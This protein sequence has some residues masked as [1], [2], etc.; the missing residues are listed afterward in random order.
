MGG[1]VADIRQSGPEAPLRQLQLGM[2]ATSEFLNCVRGVGACAGNSSGCFYCLVR[3]R[4]ERIGSQAFVQL[5]VLA[6]LRSVSR[7]H[8]PNMTKGDE[9]RWFVR[10]GEQCLP[11]K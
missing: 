10:F 2:F 1:D 11:M 8:K 9:V 5:G 7:A 3:C 4:G 6:G